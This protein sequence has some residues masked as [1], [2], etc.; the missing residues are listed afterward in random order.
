MA[1]SPSPPPPPKGNLPVL[2]YG[3]IV[4]GTVA[5]VLAIYNLIIIRWCANHRRRLRD[6][7]QELDS[8]RRMSSSSM[9]GLNSFSLGESFKYKKGD[10]DSLQLGY[11]NNECP[12]CLCVFEEDEEVRELP[13]CKHSF[14]A[15]CIEMWLYSHL[16]CPLCRAPVQFPA[17]PQNSIT[18]STLE[19]SREVLIDPSLLI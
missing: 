15:P 10:D 18:D 16:D 9:R 1:D 8:R 11:G 7:N 2:Y 4:V 19:H 5:V 3:V 17:S 13:R 6:I 12:V 14:H